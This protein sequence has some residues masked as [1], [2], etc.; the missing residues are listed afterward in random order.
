MVALASVRQCLQQAATELREDLIVDIVL[1]D[2]PSE[3]SHVVGKE[4]VAHRESVF[5][6]V[7]MLMVLFTQSQFQ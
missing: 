4:S 3:K 6:I 1:E 2:H 5:L 7:Y